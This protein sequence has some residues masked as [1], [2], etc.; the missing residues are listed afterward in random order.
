MTVINNDN[1]KTEENKEE[2][3]L[4]RLKDFGLTENESLL[5]MYLLQKGKD[6][7]G[8]KIAVGTGLHRQ[9]V[10]VSLERLLQL[11]LVESVAYGKQKKYKARPPSE[12]EKISKLR[13]LQTNDLVQELNKI[14]AI[15]NE[16]DFEVLQGNDAIRQHEI[17]Y[18]YECV[19]E[20]TEFI[21]GGH[22]EGFTQLMGEG[23][24]EY[25]HE[26][27]KKKIKVFYLGN[28]K[29]RELYKQYIGILPNQEYRF[30]E[31]LPQGVAH[32]VVRNNSVLFFSFLNPPLLYIIKSP[33]VAENYKQFFMMLWNMARE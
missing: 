16:Q 8:S 10:Y 1:L 11:R 23:L 29:E 2:Y 5:Y 3:L 9:Y 20:E 32:M 22:S 19:T 26:K 30:M 31:E 6:I 4:V 24:D 13:M 21:I 14:S 18:A 33:V 25:L 17:A 7:G 28:E 12:L 27:N 15:G